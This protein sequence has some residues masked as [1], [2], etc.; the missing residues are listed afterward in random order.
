MSKLVEIALTSYSFSD[1]E[2]LA[3]TTYSE[4]QR[5]HI[6]TERSAAMVRKAEMSPSACKSVED[7]LQKQEYE[8]GIADAY[9]Y[10]L[11]INENQLQQGIV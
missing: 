11:V 3:A 7:Y 8:R 1:E 4:L 5:Q 6:Q 2:A 9:A 10:L